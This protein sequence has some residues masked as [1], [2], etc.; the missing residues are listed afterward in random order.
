MILLAHTEGGHG[1]GGPF[2]PWEFHPA[3]NH[4][5]IAFL[6]G[7]VALDLY[8]WW[9]E[10]PTLAQVSTGLL[11]AGVLTGLLTALA[12]LLAFFTVPAHTEEAH[13]LMYWHL[14]IQAAALLLFAWPA[15]ERW[16]TWAAPPALVGRFV[17]CLA[18]VLLLIG[19]GIGG[20]IVYH[21]G[22]GIDPQLLA[23]EVRGSHSH[24]SGPAQPPH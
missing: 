6:L 4:L 23:T 17:T 24:G 15:W 11:I 18:A 7:G 10:R 2:E 9:R 20:Y 21:G 1:W 13:R 8:A 3:L 19:S 16:R 12:G 5:P 22:A 14:G